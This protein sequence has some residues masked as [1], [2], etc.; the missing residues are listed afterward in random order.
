MGFQ[1]RVFLKPEVTISQARFD[2]N[3]AQVFI[4]A[5]PPLFMDN[6][7]REHR[8][9][10]DLIRQELFS[11]VQGRAGI[12]PGFLWR[13]N[14]MAF[15]SEENFRG[16]A[17]DGRCRDIVYVLE[18]VPSSTDRK[19]DTLEDVFQDRTHLR[20]GVRDGQSFISRR[21]AQTG[22]WQG[23]AI[24][25]GR[26]IAKTLHRKPVFTPLTSVASRFTAIRYGVVDLTISLI[27]QTAE[28]GE[29]AYLSSPYF[30][31][32]LVLATLG[33]RKEIVALTSQELNNHYNTVIAVR[34]STGERVVRQRFPKVK[35][36]LVEQ[37]AKIQPEFVKLA[38]R[39]ASK[40]LFFVTD[41]LI[42]RGWQQAEV[43]HVDGSDLLA[44]D[45]QY[46]VA[47]GSSELVPIVNRIIVQ[48]KIPM[49]YN[50]AITEK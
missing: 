42:A 44:R 22:Q 47:M 43:L 8:T 32:G 13:V 39:Q 27:T 46:V 11:V 45:D 41:E 12:Q 24:R 1:L 21:N 38:K 18:S 4:K 14:L 49:L 17:R 29:R 48:E 30:Y 2:A 26:L 25:F 50:A 7:S 3:S 28:R 16:Y 37:T 20:I 36:V 9:L 34:G 15:M 10:A 40:T 19:K 31:T 33:N 23:A 5:C 35:L 6:P